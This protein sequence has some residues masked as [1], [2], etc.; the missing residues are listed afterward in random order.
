MAKRLNSKASRPTAAKRKK[1]KKKKVKYVR[2]RKISHIKE[3]GTTV[4]LSVSNVKSKEEIYANRL[5]RPNISD[6]ARLNCE[7]KLRYWQGRLK[8]F[9]VGYQPNS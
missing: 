3:D 5:R 8:E 4:L 6:E 7:E 9:E 2:G 1:K